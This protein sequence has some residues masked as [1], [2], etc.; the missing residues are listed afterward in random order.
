MKILYFLLVLFVFSALTIHAQKSPAQPIKE[1]NSLLARQIVEQQALESKTVEETDKRVNILLRIADFLWTS[2]E[3]TARKYFSEAFQIAVERFR[4]KGVEKKDG[5]NISIYMPDYRFDVIEAVAKRDAEWAKKLSEIVLKE[6]DEDKEKD[7]RDSFEKNS[8][9]QEILGI[10]A[11]AAKDNSNLS[12]TFARR[13]MRYPL[14][15][16]WYWSLYQMAGNNQSLA[17]QIYAELLLNYADAEVFRLLYLSAYPFARERIFGVEKYTLGTSV[18]AGFATNQRLKRQFLLTFMRRVMK[19][20]AENNAKSLQ[21]SIPETASAATALDELEPIVARQFPDLMQAFSQAKIHANSIAASDA[22]AAAKSREEAGSSFNKPFS[23]KLE[24]VKKAESDGNLE[25]VQIFQ[26]V[27]A[28]R[29]EEDFKQAES[30]IDKMADEEAREGTINYFNFQ[31][32][33]LATKEKRFD[34]A[35]KYALKVPKIEHRAVLFFDIAE[36]KMKEPMTKLES[37]D[38]LLEVFQTANKAPDTVEKAQVLLGLAF[39][40]EKVDHYSAL[41]SLTEAIKTANNLDGPDLFA[42]Y[43]TQEI[44]GK[45]FAHFSSYSVPGFELTETFYAFSKKDFLTALTHAANFSDKYLR[46]LAIL[47][48][49]KDCEKNDK[50]AKSKLKTK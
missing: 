8:E 38:T 32:S 23:E 7:K 15:N 11:R 48:A 22:L 33:Q 18:P 21:V 47:A 4:E 39:M 14:V 35:R 49:V 1:C 19:M 36:A 26:L 10:A 9:I 45:Y 20:T 25:D 2:D 41:G 29:T 44:K 40:Y 42:G 3:E 28:A 13:A 50:P 34:E 17:D 24:E 16:S 5:K 37:L 27:N 30:W 46:T 43:V 12:L 6:F 31:R